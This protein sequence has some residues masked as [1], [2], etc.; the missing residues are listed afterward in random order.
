MAVEDREE[1]VAPPQ[2]VEE[3]RRDS[4]DGDRHQHRQ[5]DAQ[6]R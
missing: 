4:R 6:E 2:R 1:R 5:P 3:R